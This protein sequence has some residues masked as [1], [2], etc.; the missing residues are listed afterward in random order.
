V[1][2]ARYE[3][4]LI[5]AIKTAITETGSEGNYKVIVIDGAGNIVSDAKLSDILAAV[6]ALVDDSIKG[7]LRSIGDAGDSPANSA[8]Y[9]VLSR[10]YYI[11]SRY[12]NP[13]NAE[14]FTTTPLSAGASYISPSRD[15]LLSRMGHMGAIAYSDVDSDTDGFRIELSINGTNWDYVG[16]KATVTGGTGAALEQTVVARYARVVYVNGATDQTVF[17]LGGRYFI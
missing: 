2:G 9:T 12:S 13:S 15:F 10:L 6:T 17:R 14:I 7:V 16:A 1:S 4:N 8:G 11:D 3:K 5:E